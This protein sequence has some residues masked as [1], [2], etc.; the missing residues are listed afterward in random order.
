M[1]SSL[2]RQE[3]INLIKRFRKQTQRS[4]NTADDAAKAP[5]AQPKSKVK[6][7]NSQMEERASENVNAPGDDQGILDASVYC[8]DEIDDGA[9]ILERMPFD[10]DE[11]LL[12]EGNHLL[13]QTLDSFLSKFFDQKLK[14]RETEERNLN[15]GELPLPPPVLALSLSGGVDSM[16]LLKLLSCNWLRE[17]HGNYVVL[18]LHV[19]YGN[20]GEVGISILACSLA[21]E[22]RKISE[23]LTIFL[24]LTSITLYFLVFLR[25]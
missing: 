18:S 25:Q 21:L 19:N 22:M 9:D 16:V 10:A 7:A 24:D 17:R 4:L 20:R 12:Q 11:T 14:S 5:A 3:S 23:S 6:P 2:S 1:Q 8:K 15:E 13:L